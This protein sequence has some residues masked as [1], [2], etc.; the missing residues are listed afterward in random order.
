M[1]AKYTICS[2][3]E[4]TQLMSE[5]A[6]ALS[7]RAFIGT[8]AVAGATCL[9]SLDPID[10]FA[11]TAEEKKAEAAA[12]LDSLNAMRSKLDA[13]SD[14]Y[15]TALAAQEEAEGRVVE[16]QDR[17][18]EASE[19]IAG[20][21]DQLSVRARSMYRSGSSTFIDLLLGATTFQA[22]TTNWGVLN[23]M[24]ENDAEMVQ[25]TKDL[26]AEVEEEKAVLV[27][28]E[29]KAKEAA[30]EAAATKAEAEQ[31][32]SQHQALYD[33]LNAEVQELVRQEE[34]AREAAAAAAAAAAASQ[35]QSTGH[36]G[37]SSAGSSNNNAPQAPAVGGAVGR[38][39]SKLGCPYVWGA[40]GPD[41]FDCSGFVSYCLT[42]SYGRVLGTTYT[43]A[44][45][46]QV[47]NPQPGDICW[48]SGHVGL[49]IG[50]GRMIHA[51]APGDVVREAPVQG[52]MIFRRY[53][54]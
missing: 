49:Y 48:T 35:Q 1:F 27:E 7:R 53:T 44:K 18:D 46:P 28:Q 8:A 30:A 54:G 50:G 36:Y 38:A 13:A 17:I 2:I 9:V 34:E 14:D 4:E 33:S 19:Q 21:Q 39:Y 40:G 32:V 12:A 29:Q 10:A 16:A 24:N 52:G 43:M 5:H 37:G 42:G 41:S 15:Y 45:Y 11:V 23:N 51:P 26:K 3:E 20:L 31:V 47:S 6:I 25:Q 22:F